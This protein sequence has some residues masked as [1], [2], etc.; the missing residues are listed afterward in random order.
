EPVRLARLA[1]VTAVRQ[2][3]H[4]GLML[5]GVSAPEKM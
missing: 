2:T 4:N 5:L 3:L 1:L